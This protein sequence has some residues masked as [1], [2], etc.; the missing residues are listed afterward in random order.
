MQLTMKI[1]DGGQVLVCFKTM[2]EKEMKEIE[3]WSLSVSCDTLSY[4]KLPLFAISRGDL[5]YD[6][7]VLDGHG[8]ELRTAAQPRA[9]FS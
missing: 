4:F 7:G 6:F 5:C 1:N 8:H 3:K 9:I 2:S